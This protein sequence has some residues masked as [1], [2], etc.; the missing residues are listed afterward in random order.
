M[1]TNKNS[2]AKTDLQRR[3]LI[4]SSLAFAGTAASGILTGCGGGDGGDAAEAVA[5]VTTGDAAEPL[6]EP[7][8]APVAGAY[9]STQTV[10]ISSATSG[11]TI[12][13]TIDGST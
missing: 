2:K 10:T 3:F 12:Y 5:P 6:A 13:Y 4:G 1:A 7:T 8:F 9:S 11:A